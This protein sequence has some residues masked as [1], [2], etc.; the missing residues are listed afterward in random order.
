[1]SP[2]CHPD[3]CACLCSRADAA[4]RPD[5]K[6]IG[7]GGAAIVSRVMGMILAAVAVDAVI[8]AIF[9]IIPA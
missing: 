7:K 5:P 3:V 6:L 9:D 4:C 8:N 2:P 1:L